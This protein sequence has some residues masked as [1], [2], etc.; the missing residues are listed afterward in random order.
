MAINLKDHVVF[1]DRLQMDMVPLSVA[2]KAIAEA[3]AVNEEKL[4]EALKMIEDSL[5]Q[6]NKTISEND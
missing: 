1:I 3:V 2:E 6:I 4:D 5:T